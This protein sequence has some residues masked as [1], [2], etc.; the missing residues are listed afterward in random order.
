[1]KTKKSILVLISLIALSINGFTQSWSLTGNSSIAAPPTNF[2]G[3]TSTGPQALEFQVNGVQSGWLDYLSPFKTF[4]GY[5]AG[6]NTTAVGNTAFGYNALTTNVNGTSNTAI[7]AY[8]LYT[9]SQSSAIRAANTAV[10]DSALFKNSTGIQNSAIGF[11]SSNNN[12]TGNYNTMIGATTFYHNTTGSYN[13]GGGFDAIFYNTT[14]IDNTAFGAYALVEQNA[15]GLGHGNSA[16]GAYCLKNCG[17]TSARGM[18]NSAL[19]DSSLFANTGQYNTA[20]GYQ[21][22][23]TNTTGN[24]NTTLGYKADVNGT[25]YSNATAIGANAVVGA[26]NSL[27]LGGTGTYAVNVGIGTKNPQALFHVCADKNTTYDSSF[28]VTTAG[29]VGIGT[30]TPNNLLQVAGLI[31][32]NSTSTFLGYITG[33]STGACNTSTGYQALNSITTGGNN[34][35]ANGY[36]ALY[37]NSSGNSNAGFGCGSLSYNTTGNYNVAFGYISL[38]NNTTG[39]NNTAVGV[40]ALYTST[41]NNNTALGIDA[42]Y[43]LTTGSHNVFL[44]DSAGTN[45]TYQDASAINSMALGYNT[46]TTANNQFMY[47][48]TSVAT[49]IFQAGNVGIGY[50]TPVAKLEVLALDTAGAIV[51]RNNADSVEFRVSGNGYVVARDIQVKTGIIIPDYVFEK[52][53]KLQSLSEVE[54]Y[55]NANKHLPGVPSA[56]DVKKD[57]LNVAEMDASLL[58][59]LEEQTLYII[60]LQKQIKQT[61][62]QNKEMQK[63]IDLLKGKK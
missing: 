31:N 14:G 13:T 33:N 43:K 63:E 12:T 8:S 1:M 11:W 6:L 60:D 23:A 46:Y 62:E 21:A 5:R 16:F 28:V 37:T 7:G 35:T 59:K 50:K 24:Y 52:N 42:G 30:T 27:V 34:N 57:G 54:K 3:T 48:N 40:S 29:K 49:H 15:M 39:S 19:G 44:G 41:G 53:Y 36:Y 2:I 45:N 32:F 38:M 26:S 51:V 18:D 25:G 58:K 61:Q 10:G 47:G 20:V 55:I 9:A 4:F 56:A 22:L 17:S